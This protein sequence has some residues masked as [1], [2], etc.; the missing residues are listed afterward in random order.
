MDALQPAGDNF[1]FAPHLGGSI[2]QHQGW[3]SLERFGQLL[4]EQKLD[5]RSLKYFLAST[6]CFFREIPNGI[7]ALALRVTDD[8]ID[9]DRFG[10]VSSAAPI[11]LAAVD[12]YGLGSNSSG[13]NKNH[14][15]LFAIMAKRFGITETDFHNPDFIIP[16]AIDL[17]RVTRQLYREGS[18]AK[19]VGFHYA[20]EIT[21]ER[22]FELC[23]T[24]LARHLN[25]YAD[26]SAH[27]A[28]EKFLD[29]YYVHTIVEAE[30]GEASAQAVDIYS[31]SET[32]RQAQLDG[33]DEFM[34]AY[35]AFWSAL[36]RALQ[37]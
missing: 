33:A 34:E 26:S 16:E 28:A 13:N 1:N 35:G 31:D 9:A 27:L 23:Y 22:E 8:R 25:E 32:D 21:S 24:G 29:F 18:V 11:L 12:E 17:A 37:R 15:Q 4:S 30:H 10:A 2:Q 36:T 5:D 19:S 3:T 6:A 20:S 14:H 7:L